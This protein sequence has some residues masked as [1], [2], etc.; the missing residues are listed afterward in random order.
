[1]LQRFVFGSYRE[2]QVN[3]GK[4]WC[5]FSW[6]VMVVVVVIGFVTMS[7]KKSLVDVV[8]KMEVDV[9]D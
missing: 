1:M 5:A 2:L 8:L 6:N 3:I 7:E 9:R 4:F